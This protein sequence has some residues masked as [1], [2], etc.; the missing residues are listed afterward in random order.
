MGAWC[1]KNNKGQEVICE[2]T[3]RPFDYLKAVLE[4]EDKGF[5]PKGLYSNETFMKQQNRGGWCNTCST[6][7][8]QVPRLEG[9]IVPNGTFEKL[10]IN[11][12][13]EPIE[14]K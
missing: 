10:G 1:V 13:G 11:Y 2:C 3:S 6:G 4:S 8:Y 12:Q 9:V 7:Y 14:L 5:L